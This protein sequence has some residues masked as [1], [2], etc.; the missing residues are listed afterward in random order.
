VSSV[1]IAPD[2]LVAVQPRWVRSRSD[3]QPFQAMLAGAL[4]D[5]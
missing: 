3:K 4:A 1:V 5:G 2:S